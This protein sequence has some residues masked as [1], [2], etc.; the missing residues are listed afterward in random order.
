MLHD[1]PESEKTCSCGHGLT[2]IGEEKSEKLDIIPAKIQVE[3]HVRPKYACKH[4]EGTSDETL[5]V[6]RISPFTIFDCGNGLLSVKQITHFLRGQSLFVV[7]QNGGQFGFIQ[8]LR[9][10]FIQFF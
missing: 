1:I 9:Q 5:S 4:C 2:R 3:V 10:R 6:V 7:P 8:P